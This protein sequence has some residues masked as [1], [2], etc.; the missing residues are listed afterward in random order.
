MSALDET[1]RA[2]GKSHGVDQHLDGGVPALHSQ[3]GADRDKGER[4][5]AETNGSGTDCRKETRARPQAGRQGGRE[6]G[7]QGGR[8]GGR[9]GKGGV[10]CGS[11]PFENIYTTYLERLLLQWEVLN[12]NI[13]SMSTKQAHEA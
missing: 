3:N 7:R 9:E 6:R 12:W 8:E 1:L 11:K 5:S 13:F 2:S 4:R 10:H